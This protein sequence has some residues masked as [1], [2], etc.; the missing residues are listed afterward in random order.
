MCEP[1]TKTATQFSNHEGMTYRSS[2]RANFF[3]FIEIRGNGLTKKP[4]D[5][6]VD[7]N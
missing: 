4:I 2:I 3:I 6:Y 7:I 1:A 5:E